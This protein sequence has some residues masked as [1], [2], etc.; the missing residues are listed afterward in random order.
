MEIGF[1]VKDSQHLELAMEQAVYPKW[2][3]FGDYGC[4]KRV[5]ELGKLK[6]AA[7]GIDVIFHYISPKVNSALMEYE[8]KKVMSFLEQGIS[9]SINDLGLLYKMQREVEFTSPVYLGRLLT[10]SV[11]RWVWGKLHISR[12][13]EPVKEYFSQNNFFQQEKMELFRKWNIKGIETTAFP[14]EEKSLAG[15]KEQGFRIIGFADQTIAAVA[16]AC[17]IARDRGI[18]VKDNECSSCCMNQ[19]IK[20]EPANEQQKVRYPELKLEGTVLMKT[21]KPSFTWDGYETIVFSNWNEETI[22]AVQKIQEG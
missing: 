12:E 9:V 11:N 7:S 1:Y 6:E 5:P 13:S 14:E 22:A 2:I 10:K 17:P 16:R 21:I 20:I 15:I 18:T 3:L 19:E 4:Y 8:Y